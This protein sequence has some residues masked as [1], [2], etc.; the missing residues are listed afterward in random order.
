MRNKKAQIFAAYLVILTLFLC[1]VFILVYYNQYRNTDSSL[2]SPVKLL[3]FGD[4]KEL[5]EIRQEKLIIDSAKQV[6]QDIGKEFWGK[7]IFKR[8]LKQKFCENFEKPENSKLKEF[9]PDFKNFCTNSYNFD[10]ENDNLASD[11]KFEKSFILR[12]EQ[13][14]AISFIFEIKYNYDKKVIIPKKEV[15]N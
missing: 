8:T 5:F 13:G 15:I 12:P 10:F 4:K 2:V 3:E 11:V 9:P 1:F 6:S 14:A 7:E